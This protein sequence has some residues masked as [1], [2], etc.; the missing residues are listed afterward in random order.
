MLI[1]ASFE[2]TLAVF[3]KVA[4]DQTDGGQKSFSH[5]ESEQSTGIGVEA[6]LLQLRAKHV[7]NVALQ[8]F[9]QMLQRFER[10]V[11]FSHFH[12]LKR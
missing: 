8:A 5:Q 12:A 7:T 11:L 6:N 3:G 10:D 1:R 4:G 9:H 2:A